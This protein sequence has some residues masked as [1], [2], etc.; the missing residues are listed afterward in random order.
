MNKK[1]I[2][3]LAMSLCMIAILAV[4]GSLAYLTD[5]EQATNVFTTGSVEIK[6]DE[7]VVEEDLETG[8]LVGNENKPVRTEKGQTYD[9]HPNM[10][11][12]KDP[13]IWI[14]AG[15]EPS[16]V[17]AIV[18]VTGKGVNDKGESLNLHD[19]F[20]MVG[21][22]TNSLLDINKLVRGDKDTVFGDMVADP[23]SEW[24]TYGAANIW[25]F[26]NKDY[27]IHQVAN[28]N[29]TWTF[30]IFVKNV[31]YSE[32]AVTLFDKLV[33]S[34][35]FDND[36]MKYLDNLN[37]D[38]KAYATQAHGF[39]EESAIDDEKFVLVDEG[40][41]KA[42]TTAFNKDWRFSAPIADV[43]SRLK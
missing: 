19:L 24:G 11:V 4:G 40:C 2:A 12:E 34:P 21:D 10:Y 35:K 32:D 8:D 43:E 38:V 27:A 23:T 41:Y 42:M 14:H 26:Q 36:Q 25:V 18:T 9:L 3:L 31:Q 20:D 17:G 22:E 7:V 30:Y 15:S 29:N 5:T 28:G 6:L 13:T 37:I 16:Y 39:G 33:I 1:K